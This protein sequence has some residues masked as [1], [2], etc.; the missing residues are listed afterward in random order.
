AKMNPQ[1]KMLATIIAKSLNLGD[2]WTVVDVEMRD[3]D[4]D[5]DELHVYIERTPG[6][7]LR[8]PRCGAMHGVYDTRERTWRHLDIWQYK[9]YIHCK[10]PRLDCEG[11]PITA[12]VPWAAPDAKHFTALFEAQVLVMA[13][14]SMP[15]AGI[16]KVVGEHDTRI[17]A[18]L[19]RIVAKAHAEAN[20]SGVSD[21]GVDETARKRGHNY[22]TSFVDLKGERVMVCALGRDAS[23]VAEFACELAEHGGDPEAVKVVTCDLSPA[24]AKGVTEHL[25]N[26]KRVADRFHVIQLATRQLDKVRA[27]EA[28][29]SK[30]KRALLSRTKYIWL[31]N[32][33]N[34]T[35][36]QAERKRNLS[37]EHLKT[38]RACAMKEALQT[39]YE[40]E[41]RKE[42]ESDLNALCSWIMHSNVPQMKS[43]AKTIREN[44]A[45]ILNYF[46]HR[47]T[48]AVLEGMNSIIQSAKRQAR[49]FSNLEYFKT[50]IYL[51]L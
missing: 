24:F 33:A 14:S 36:G 34:L 30:E 27:A 48:N 13:M 31:K 23:T 29:E 51:N 42:A 16:A 7:A 12:E 25:P 10:L 37:K 4:P 20:F 43:V 26:A 35:E 8:C 19:N 1:T 17:W 18:M 39:V 49:G 2:E 22:L 46:D 21:V 5:P 40:C 9:T 38:A 50:I 6:Y 47:L 44:W 3:C 28:R 15:V 41:T 32:E 45:E 11:G